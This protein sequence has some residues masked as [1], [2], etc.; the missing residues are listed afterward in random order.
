MTLIDL[1]VSFDDIDVEAQETVSGAR[2]VAE[3][4]ASCETTRVQSCTIDLDP[5]P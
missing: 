2:H 3:M 5:F 1:E 4:A